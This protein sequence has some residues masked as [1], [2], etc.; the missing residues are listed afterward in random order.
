MSVNPIVAVAVI[1]VVL[2]ISICCLNLIRKD[3]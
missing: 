3:G 1:A 2:F